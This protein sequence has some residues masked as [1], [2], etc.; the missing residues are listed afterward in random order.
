[1]SKLRFV[2]L[3]LAAIVMTGGTGIVSGQSAASGSG[4][5]YPNRPIRMVAGAPGGSSDFAARTVSQGISGP[6]GQNVIVENRSFGVMAIEI[7]AKA[8]PDG[9]TLLYYGSAL[10]IGPLFQ[11]MSYDPVLDLAPVSMALSSPNILLVHPG[12]PAKSVK[13]LVAL[14]KAKP[15]TL[16]YASGETGSSGHL[17]AELFKH[18]TGVNIVR[19]PFKGQGPALTA[20]LGGEVQMLIA[21]A[22]GM[23]GH[24]N[25]GR[26]RALAVTGTQRIS[27]FP[28][29]PTVS[30]AGVPG[31]EAVQRSGVWVP[32][33]TPAT[34][35]NRLQQE[36]TRAVR[37]DEVRARFA[38]D[39][40]DPVG[41]SPQEFA[42]TIKAEMARMGKVIKDANL[43]IQ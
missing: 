3:I 7:V 41:S 43:R 10:W 36:I 8:P 12:V 20:L 42:T 9:Y 21:S 4:Q 39:G 23:A 5:A 24:I 11:K 18:M 40:V 31:Y 38:N 16:N 28:D 22:G 34:I 13:E 27:A 32:P 15:G 14:A 30:E 25:S 17:S 29:L 2:T 6:L 37:S 19:V 26:M 35:V 33:K 1:M